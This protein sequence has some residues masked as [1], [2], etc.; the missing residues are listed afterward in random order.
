MSKENV[1]S[2]KP[3]GVHSFNGG[4]NHEKPAHP[5]GAHDRGKHEKPLLESGGHVNAKKPIAHIEDTTH[6]SG[7]P[8]PPATKLADS[9]ILGGKLRKSDQ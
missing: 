9:K 6:H 8:H 4:K 5:Q 3:S 1:S 2:E 7:R